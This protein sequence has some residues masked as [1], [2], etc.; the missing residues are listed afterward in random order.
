MLAQLPQMTAAEI[1]P[2]APG[3]RVLVV[4]GPTTSVPSALAEVAGQ[5]H[6]VHRMTVSSGQ[7]QGMFE[8]LDNPGPAQ[9]PGD[10]RH[11][12]RAASARNDRHGRSHDARP[13]GEHGAGSGEVGSLLLLPAPCSLPRRSDKAYTARKLRG[14]VP[15]KFQQLAAGLGDDVLCR[16]PKATSISGA[17]S[18]LT[19]SRSATSPCNGTVAVPRPDSRP[20]PGL[21]S[22]RP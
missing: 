9:Q 19:L 17:I 8:F 22:R 15:E 21:L 3:H 1:S 13:G 12:L 20:G 2:L 14:V 7:L 6:E 18:T 10:K 16:S 4:V 11:I 5:G